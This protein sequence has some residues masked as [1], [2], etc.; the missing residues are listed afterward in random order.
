MSRN[1]PLLPLYA[2]VAYT[3]AASCCTIFLPV[4]SVGLVLQNLL[5]LTGRTDLHG[6]IACCSYNTSTLMIR[7]S[8]FGLHVREKSFLSYN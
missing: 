6:R 3:G 5:V 4:C 8:D 1:V 7:V 2:F